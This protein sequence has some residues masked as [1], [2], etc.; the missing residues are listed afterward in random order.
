MSIACLL[1]VHYMPSLCIIQYGITQVCSTWQAFRIQFH[2]I[3]AFAE[4]NASLRS[5]Y[6]IFFVQNIHISIAIIVQ[7]KW[8]VF[9]NN[10]GFGLS[11]LRVSHQVL[12]KFYTLLFKLLAKQHI[13]LS[14]FL[15][16]NLLWSLELQLELC[17]N[18][19]RQKPLFWKLQ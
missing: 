13:K 9:F 12:I 15:V 14:P 18:W 6:Y 1:Y 11:D 3:P 5:M 2:S 17:K 10:A 8:F 4:V 7:K 19:K 16:V